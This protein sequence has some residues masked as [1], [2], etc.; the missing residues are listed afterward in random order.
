MRYSTSA[1]RLETPDCTEQD[2][3]VAQCQGDLS[4]KEDSLATCH[5]EL[6][7]CEAAAAD[8]TVMTLQDVSAE[9]QTVNSWYMGK[10]TENFDKEFCI[11]NGQYVVV[12]NGN[13]YPTCVQYNESFEAACD[14]N[15]V[16]GRQV[17]RQQGS[18]GQAANQLN[19]ALERADYRHPDCPTIQADCNPVKEW[20]LDLWGL[21]DNK[22]LCYRQ[23]SDVG[24]H[25]RVVQHDRY[26]DTCV[27]FYEDFKVDD[28]FTPCPEERDYICGGMDNGR[29]VYGWPKA[30]GDTLKYALNSEGQRHPQ[31]SSLLN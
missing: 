31:C 25:M 28:V 15:L 16:C 24:G 12:E 6:E 23:D 17:E 14:D 27:G 21:A 18:A 7:T 5:G 1:V 4:Q 29:I 30:Q 13:T 10:S 26:V 20:W 22:N 2:A 3:S 11:Y 9:C 8:K 19:T